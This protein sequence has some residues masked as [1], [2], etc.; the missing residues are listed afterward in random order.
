MEIGTGIFLGCVFLGVIYVCVKINN[1]KKVIKWGVGLPIGILAIIGLG[2]YLYSEWENRS[3]VITSLDGISIGEKINDVFFKHPDFQL[4]N[5][6][7]ETSKESELY[8]NSDKS[9]RISVKGGRVE[10]IS[11]FCKEDYDY[12][13]I[14][15]VACGDSGDDL[16]SKLGDKIRIRCSKSDPDFSEDINLQFKKFSRAYDDVKHGVRYLMW[17]NKVDGFFVIDNKELETPKNTHWQKC[18]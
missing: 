11:H 7:L 5:S 16:L 8:E 1:W 2:L 3:K 14:N 13:N 18:D 17:K 4:Y 10:Y 6:N 15:G 9:V 12:T